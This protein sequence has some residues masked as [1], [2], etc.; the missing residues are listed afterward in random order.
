MTSPLTSKAQ[1]LTMSP[2]KLF[3]PSGPDKT[4]FISSSKEVGKALDANLQEPDP[5]H[6]NVLRD[7][8]IDATNSR[9]RRVIQI[10]KR[11]LKGAG[12]AGIT[13]R[14]KL[15]PH[16]KYRLH[17]GAIHPVMM[18]GAQANGLAP[19]RRQQ[20]RVMAARGLR[21][22]RSGSVDV[23]YDMNPTKAD[24]GDSIILQHIHTVWKVYHTFD[25]SA[26]HLFSIGWNLALDLLLKAKYRRHD[27]TGPMQALQAYFLDYD[28]DI[29]NGKL[30]KRTGYGRIPD[31]EIRLVDGWPD[32]QHKLLEEFRW[33]RLLRLTRYQGCHDLE[34][35]LDWT[36]SLSAQKMRAERQ[37]TALRAFHQGTL[38]GQE[39]SCLLCGEDPTFIHLLWQ[40][41][42]WEGRVKAL[43]TQWQEGLRVGTD[44]ELWNRG[45]TQ[46][47]SYIQDGGM[48][49]N[50]QR[51]RALGEP[52]NF[53]FATGHACSVA[54]ALICKDPRR[55]RY[56]F[57][58]CVHQ[59]LTK[60][61]VASLTGICPGK[62]TRNR[63]FFYAPKHLS[64]HVSDKVH[65][66]IFSHSVWKMWSWMA[67]YEHFLD[68][69]QDLERE[70]FDQVRLR[71][72]S[73]HKID[74]NH[75]RKLF[76]KD[77][78][79]KAKQAAL[80]AWPEEILDLQRHVDE[81][82]RD[83]LFAAAE[84]MDILLR[85]KSHFLHKKDQVDSPAKVRLIQQK[86]DLLAH[87]LARPDQ[88]GHQWKPFRSAVQCS[89]CKTRF[90]AKS[91]LKE[92]KEGLSTPCSNATPNKEIRK[93][94]FEVI[95]DLLEA[96][97]TPP[98][99]HF[100]RLDKAYLRCQQCRSYM[101]ARASEEQFTRF[102]C[103]L[104]MPSRPLEAS[105]W[106][107][108]PTHEMQRLGATLECIHCRAKTKMVNEKVE[109]TGKLKAS[110]GRPRSKDLRTFSQTA[111]TWRKRRTKKQL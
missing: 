41:S 44:P 31:C 78:Q 9:R 87:S 5:K 14:L 73:S 4:G 22:Q 75:N 24:A 6:Y 34:R 59:V 110:C 71:L 61:R 80:L 42:F 97:G 30:W 12:R 46:S 55:K 47:L 51:R 38:H 35:P 95:H 53:H 8:G 56:V 93:T 64:M 98:G 21:L 57:A 103:G 40:R 66:A 3:W 72:F 7:L 79:A 96:Q 16:V 49:T 20:I 45:M 29:S 15:N 102:D 83:I 18:W 11:Y 48:A 17:R 36:V 107:G 23:V 91:L 60:E 90:H 105:K 33:Q 10:K 106:T 37:S 108:H 19:Q 1:I 76:Q 63:A 43:P 88:H 101:L 74:S 13:H 68:L 77:T 82:T 32:L 50:V 58:I 100:L 86:R 104:P 92:I 81:D 52:G 99:E 65:V 111:E 89:L 94:R 85:D 2:A 54:I 70:D 39:G 27:V 109:L 67:A 69:C 25:E 26:Q 84:R 62:A 28:F